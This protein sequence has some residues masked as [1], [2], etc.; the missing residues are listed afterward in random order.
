MLDIELQTAASWTAYGAHHVARGTDIP[1]V[2][3][4]AWGYWPAA[5]PGVE[6]LGDL[7][8]CRVLDIGSGTARY[9]AHLARRG[10]QVDA[11]EASPTQHDRAVARY[12]QRPGLRLI[13]GDAVDHLTHSAP[14]DVIYSIHGIPY[15][16]PHRLLPALTSTLRPGGGR[17][18]F[19]ALHTSSDGDGPSTSVAPRHETLI[20]AGG[21]PVS[22]GMW[23]LSPNLW[24][25]LLVEHGLHVDRVDILTAPEGDTPWSC[26][27][28]QAHRPSAP[29]TEGWH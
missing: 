28:I 15:I 8:D 24:A 3:R 17:L 26:T 1:E 25:D 23:V 9:A 14:Y 18:V 2:D 16:A 11:V 10:V 5:G 6:I 4:L 7:A 22:V 21:E 19:S 20:P 27:L 29:V 12:G 13:H